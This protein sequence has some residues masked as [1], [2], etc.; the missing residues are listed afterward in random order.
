[1][2]CMTAIMGHTTHEWD[3]VTM[4]HATCDPHRSHN[5]ST[6]SETQSQWVIQHLTCVTTIMGHTTHNIIAIMGHTAHDLY[7]N[8]NGSHNTWPVWHHNG[9]YNTW[10]AYMTCMAVTMG[11]WVRQSHNGS[12]NAQHSHNQWTIQHDECDTQSQWVTQQMTNMT[13]SHKIWQ[14][15]HSQNGPY[16][17]W[18]QHPITMGQITHGEN[19]TLPMNTWRVW[20]TANTWQVRHTVTMGHTTWQVT[21]KIPVGNT[22]RDELDTDWQSHATHDEW[23]TDTMCCETS[24]QAWHAIT[25]HPIMQ[26]TLILCHNANCTTH[27]TTLTHH[28]NELYTAKLRV[29]HESS[30]SFEI[31]RINTHAQGMMVTALQHTHTPSLNLTK[32]TPH[33]KRHY[34]LHT[35]GDR[36][37]FFV[38]SA[39]MRPLSAFKSLQCNSVQ[40]TIRQTAKIIGQWKSGQTDNPQ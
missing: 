8:H 30:H 35:T 10:P 26:M 13:Q 23:I 32:F 38:H 40:N 4:G 24:W 1:M 29:L 39:N 11:Q 6:V 14:L 28:K 21:N 17:T 31:N 3:A 9:S 12:Y 37:I 20:H 16:N 18:V 25:M 36:A 19:D 33:Q 2:T 22:K 5:G 15:R 34:K 27:H 7:D